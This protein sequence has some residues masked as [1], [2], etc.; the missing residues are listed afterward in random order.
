MLLY[1]A[2]YRDNCVCVT[3]MVLIFLVATCTAPLFDLLI[4]AQP[5]WLV[6]AHACKRTCNK[7]E[8]VLTCLTANMSL[9]FTL[10]PDP[11]A[12]NRGLERVCIDTPP[13]EQRSKETPSVKQ[14]WPVH[15]KEQ[16]THY[17]SGTQNI[18]SAVICQ[19]PCPLWEAASCVQAGTSYDL[20]PL[21]ESGVPNFLLG[22]VH[23]LLVIFLKALSL[24]FRR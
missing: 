20:S 23:R 8:Q 15:S 21:R 12:S 10:I 16:H 18:S 3:L 6:R 13:R 9:S 4:E 2:P 7:Y 22:G 24:I 14:K 5:K 19:L 17:D 1:S 11:H